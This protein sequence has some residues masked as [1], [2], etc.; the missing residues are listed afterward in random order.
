M[1][2]VLM[3]FCTFTSLR[4]T[5]CFSP[6]RKGTRGCIPAGVKR[7]VESFSGIREAPGITECPLPLKN[8]M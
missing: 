8:S 7:I 5:G 4:P 3:H 2:P 6:R 1:S